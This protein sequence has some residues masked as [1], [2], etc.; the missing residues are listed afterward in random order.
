M[1]ELKATCDTDWLTTTRIDEN[2]R[3]PEKMVIRQTNRF[4]GFCSPVTYQPD[5]GGTE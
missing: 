4:T 1:K 5:D 2:R 3:T